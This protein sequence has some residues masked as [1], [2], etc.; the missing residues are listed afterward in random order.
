MQYEISRAAGLPDAAAFESLLRAVDAAALVDRDPASGALRVS[1]VV[2]A[3][4][5]SELL[6]RAGY[7]LPATQITRLPSQCCGGCGG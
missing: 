3:A 1:S 5:L 7:E 6:G 4:E 2:A